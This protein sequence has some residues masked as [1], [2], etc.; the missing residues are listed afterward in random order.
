MFMMPPAQVEMSA[1]SCSMIPAK[2]LHTDGNVG[3]V[4]AL[5][6]WFSLDTHRRLGE[7]EK[8]RVE[9]GGREGKRKR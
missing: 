4:D 8:R 6:A 3:P 7:R 9:E 5:L 2:K 1:L